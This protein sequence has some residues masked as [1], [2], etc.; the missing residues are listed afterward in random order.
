MEI[1]LGTAA[2]TGKVLA[3]LSNSDLSLRGDFLVVVD[4]WW[5]S[6]VMP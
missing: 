4:F 6:H 3:S 2:L 1:D 5:A